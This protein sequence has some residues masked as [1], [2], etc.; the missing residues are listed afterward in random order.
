[1]RYVLIAALMFVAGPIKAGDFDYEAEAALALASAKLKPVPAPVVV[2]TKEAPCDFCKAIGCGC[3]NCGCDA[4]Y[5]KKAG[6]VPA[7]S[8][9]PKAGLVQH[10]GHDC[11]SCGY[12][13]YPGTYQVRG[14]G[15]ARGTHT[16]S[17]PKCGQAWYH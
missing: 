5:G 17:C 9:F 15:P 4:Y 13:S 2:P 6:A 16:H 3:A 1:M 8:T 12:N 10:A 14:P 7:A 11:P